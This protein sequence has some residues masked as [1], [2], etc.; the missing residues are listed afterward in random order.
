VSDRP[1]RPSISRIHQLDRVLARDPDDIAARVE[2]AGLHREQDAYEAAKTDYLELLR[3]RP[4]DFGALNDFGTMVLKAGYKE[5]A[6]SLFSEAVRYHPD[7]P[8]GRVNLGNLLFLLDEFE[9]A[10][11]HFEAALRA[12]PNHVHAHR[13]MGNVLAELGDA[14]GA[15]VHRDR[16]FTKDFLT[17]LP[18]RGDWAPIR[19]L[20]LVSAQGGNTPTAS[21]LDDRLFQTTVLVTEYYYAK[22][23]LPAHDVVFNGIG[24]AD[25]CGEGLEAACEVLHRTSRPVINHPRAVMKTGRASNAARLRDLPNIVAPRMAS[26]PL[27]K[28]TGSDAAA[29]V[30]R[31]GFRF[32][33][34][35]RVPG[36]HTGRHF[37]RVESGEELAAA[38]GTL[39]G[40]QV[41][42]IEQLDARD[43]TGMHRKF[44]VM[45]VDRKLYPLHLAIARDWKVH[46]FRAD[47]AESAENR[48][49]EGP[50]LTDMAGFIGQRGMA[51]LARI[52]ATLDLDYGGID[53]AVDAAGNILFFEGNATMVMAPLAPDAKWDYRRPG[54]DAVFAAVRG[55]LR[56]R[57]SLTDAASA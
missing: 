41:W 5:A 45:I 8:M 9:D 51:A 31:Y 19:V 53:F 22:M 11:A 56:E 54:F 29:V 6:R 16:G 14:L 57:A 49:Q 3:R 36:F 40:D 47:M 30:A 7:N 21:L 25:V 42:L 33:L 48:A 17:A 52:N 24:D 26:V 35:L 2:R 28:L 44:R 39:P 1:P 13:G 34:L 20:L 27:H 15:R 23:P 12:D 18:Y 10:R 38:A 50:F 32:P 55:M 46:Y 37:I 43:G 4:T